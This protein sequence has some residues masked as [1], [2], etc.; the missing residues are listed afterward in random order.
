MSDKA[1]SESGSAGWVHESCKRARVQSKKTARCSDIVWHTSRN[2]A[3]EAAATRAATRT[4]ERIV[5]LKVKLDVNFKIE[6]TDF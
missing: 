4:K 2:G 3:A 5:L 6:P 1:P